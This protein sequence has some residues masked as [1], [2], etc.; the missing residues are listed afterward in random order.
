MS[1]AKQTS[2]ESSLTTIREAI[3][4][5]DKSHETLSALAKAKN[6]SDVANAI[7]STDISY[8]KSD[9]SEIKDSLK[10]I[11]DDF[12]THSEFLAFRDKLQEQIRPIK[13][14]VYGLVGGILL[15][16]LA[17]VLSLVIK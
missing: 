14:I 5:A 11:R 16:V 1:P 10:T 7:V 12:V 15:A 6:E 4:L 8:I 3:A 9:I 17:G 13:N 2:E